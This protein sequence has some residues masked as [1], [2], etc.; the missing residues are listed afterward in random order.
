MKIISIFFIL[1]LTS[2]ILV[3]A[4]DIAID[5]ESIIWGETSIDIQL[6]EEEIENLPIIN[7]ESFI[8]WEMGGIIAVI[9]IFL[10]IGYKIKK[11][12]RKKIEQR[13]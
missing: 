7:D 8:D 10:I 5:S 9:I 2:L 12:A 6:T 4:Q 3:G 13:K 11:K 1:I